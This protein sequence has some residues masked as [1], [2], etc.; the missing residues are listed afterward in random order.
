MHL[1]DEGD[2]LDDAKAVDG[3]EGEPVMSNDTLPR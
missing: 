3:P 2:E 1:Q